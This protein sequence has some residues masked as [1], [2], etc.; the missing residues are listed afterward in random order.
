MI[1]TL[2]GHQLSISSEFY[3]YELT[4]TPINTSFRAIQACPDILSRTLSALAQKTGWAFTVLL[5][6]PDPMG[7]GDISVARFVFLR[8]CDLNNIN[9]YFFSVHVGE[10][11]M[12]ANFSHV[13]SKYESAVL[14]PYTQFLESVFRKFRNSFGGRTGSSD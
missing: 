2:I 9:I 4:F 13:Y 11:E 6:G 14:Q 5:R 1:K 12:K 7:D 8:C 10:T 3:T